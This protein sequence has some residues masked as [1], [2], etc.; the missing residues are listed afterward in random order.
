MSVDATTMSD[1]VMAVTVVAGAID[2]NGPIPCTAAQ[3]LTMLVIRIVA[4]APVGP[5]RIAAHSRNGNCTAS[6]VWLDMTRSAGIRLTELLRF[7]H[8]IHTRLAASTT[9]S[10]RGLN[11]P[12]RHHRTAAS[13]PPTTAG[14]TVNSARMLLVVRLL[15]TRQ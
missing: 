14:T 8:A 11:L 3:A 7:S 9:T 4:P 2:A 15:Q 12:R 6:G 5:K 13:V 10:N 1:S